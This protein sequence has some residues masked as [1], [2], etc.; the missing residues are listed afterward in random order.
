MNT[1]LKVT[2]A[3][4][5]IA[6]L[7]ACDML[8]LNRNDSAGG[9]AA[10]NVAAGNTSANASADAGG[11]DPA[12]AAGNSSTAS[13]SSAPFT[14]E[15]T[16]AFLVG[17]WTDTGDCTKTIEF[18]DDGSFVTEN[19]NGMWTLNGARLTFQGSSTVSAEVAAPNADTI[20]LTHP[21]G[22]VG[23]STRCS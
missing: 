13:S 16:A 10:S 19:G 6:A 21:D 4:A 18:R 12:A 8:G 3:A 5:A 11:K 15:V 20:M 9:N 22:S 14:G 1:I 7:G 17:R 23:R 2:T